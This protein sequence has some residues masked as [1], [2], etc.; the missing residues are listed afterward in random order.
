M[1]FQ[2]PLNL[3]Y[4]FVNVL[5]GSI[6]IFI[7][8]SVIFIAGMAAR[9]GMQNIITL[10]IVVLYIIMLAGTTLYGGISG[11]YLIAILIVGLIAFS[12][13]SKAFK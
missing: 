5:S 9:F 4:W 7:F 10:S 6:D 12:A 11:L 1:S 8:L 3:E 2:Q 13:F